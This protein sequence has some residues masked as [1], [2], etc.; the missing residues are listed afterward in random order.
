MPCCHWVLEHI[1]FNLK[2]PFKLFKKNNLFGLKKLIYIC[3]QKIKKTK[4]KTSSYI[5]KTNTSRPFC[6]CWM[7]R[8][9]L[10]LKIISLI[11]HDP[12]HT[13]V[14]YWKKK[15]WNN[16]VH[17]PYSFINR[18]SPEREIVCLSVKTNQ[19]RS[20]KRSGFLFSVA[21]KNKRDGVFWEY[22]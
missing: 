7:Y 6:R 14:F 13:G 12:G 16:I 8:V 2:S 17:T 21:S 3:A 18:V 19:A 5:A 4:W 20:L 10:K 9:M 1:G 22:E 11:Y 15:K